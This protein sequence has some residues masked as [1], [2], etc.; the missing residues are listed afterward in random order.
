MSADDFANATT[1]MDGKDN[2][3][4]FL[5]TIHVDGQRRSREHRKGGN[6]EIARVNFSDGISGFLKKKVPNDRF[7]HRQTYHA[8]WSPGGQCQHAMI[9]KPTR[10][11]YGPRLGCDD[12][13][14]DLV[15]D[16]LTTPSRAEVDSVN[17]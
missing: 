14:T 12:R 13:I 10:Q 3:G 5:D 1:M 8:F 6:T 2:G 16:R 11:N 7:G 9:Q 4:G 17:M 15:T